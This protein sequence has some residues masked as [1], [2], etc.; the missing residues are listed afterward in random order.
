MHCG[1]ILE[2][3]QSAMR[4]S[5]GWLEMGMNIPHHESVPIAEIKYRR[6]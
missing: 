1:E 3:R 5:C 2:G 6:L 4:I